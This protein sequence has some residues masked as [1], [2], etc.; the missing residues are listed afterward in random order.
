MDKGRV[1]GAGPLDEIESDPALPLAL[2]RDA[3]VTLDG[4]IEAHDAGYG[5]VTIGVR[6]GSLVVPAPPAA[7]GERRRVRVIAGDVSLTREPPGPSSIL[8]VLAA[9]VVS[10]KPIGANEIVAVLALGADGA[11][12]APPVAPDAKVVGGAWSRAKG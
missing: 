11:R 5:L 2:A 6:G 8:N 9:R 1:I 3:A 10:M 12:R 7:I 4:V